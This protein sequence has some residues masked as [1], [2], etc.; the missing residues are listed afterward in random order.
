MHVVLWREVVVKNCVDVF[1]LN[2]ACVLIGLAELGVGSVEVTT[3][4]TS[5][6]GN[7]SNLGESSWA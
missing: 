2:E 1:K 7:L 3:T 6:G 4:A 5:N